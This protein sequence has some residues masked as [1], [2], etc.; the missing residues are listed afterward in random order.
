MFLTMTVTHN[1]FI[2]GCGLKFE[3][4]GKNFLTCFAHNK[5]LSWIFP[6]GTW[7][8]C[9]LSHNQGKIVAKILATTPNCI[10]LTLYVIMSESSVH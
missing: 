7:Q 4:V 10:N 3:G 1:V 2:Y 8:L 6:S 9:Y 5:Y